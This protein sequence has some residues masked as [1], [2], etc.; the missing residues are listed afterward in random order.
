[1]IY[2]LNLALANSDNCISYIITGKDKYLITVL[3][4]NLTS[5]STNYG[6]KVTCF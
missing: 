4:L 1:M 6:N 3:K 5:I 2:I